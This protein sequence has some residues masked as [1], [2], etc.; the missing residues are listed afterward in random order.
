MQSEMSYRPSAGISKD[1][2]MFETPGSAVSV[3]DDLW[4]DKVD[5]DSQFI[6]SAEAYQVSIE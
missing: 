4:F 1:V 6:K 5:L 3:R 2:F